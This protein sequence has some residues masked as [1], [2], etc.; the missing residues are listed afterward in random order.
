MLLEHTPEF[1]HLGEK[2]GTVLGHAFQLAQKG[3]GFLIIVGGLQ[4]EILHPVPSQD[5][6][7]MFLLKARQELQLF[8]QIREQALTGFD[9][10]VG[11]GEELVEEFIR[12]VWRGLAESCDH[13]CPSQA[14]TDE[15]EPH[16]T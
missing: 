5:R 3:T 4:Y 14:V 13:H 12:L 8:L 11:R 7:K 9:C 6:E 16:G 15:L 1:R 10:C 2:R